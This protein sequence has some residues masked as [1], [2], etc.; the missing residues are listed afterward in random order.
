VIFIGTVLEMGTETALGM[1]MVVLVL[2]SIAMGH[3]DPTVHTMDLLEVLVNEENAV[4]VTRV[5]LGCV[6]SFATSLM[7]LKPK[8]CKMSLVELE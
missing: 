3:Q 6:S 8:S 4:V 2:Q 7:I 5:H 1:A